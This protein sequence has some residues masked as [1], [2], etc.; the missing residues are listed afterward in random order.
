TDGISTFDLTSL[1]I[2]I[3]NGDPSLTVDWY[4]SY[5][6]EAADLPIPSP[7]AFQNNSAPHT[8]IASVTSVFGCNSLVTITLVIF[9]NPSPNMNPTPLEVCDDNNYG[10]YDGWDL[11]LA[12]PDIVGGEPD[13]SVVYWETLAEAQNG[14]PGTEI[15]MPYTNA[16]PFN[17]I[18]YARVTKSVPPA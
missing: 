11:Y 1:F 8:V 5:A 10:I 14:V 7:S 3:V 6:D 16:V 4:L 17:Q 12:F 15:V 18:V 2:E 13:V 9:P